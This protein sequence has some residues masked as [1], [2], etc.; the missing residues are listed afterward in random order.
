VTTPIL[1]KELEETGLFDVT[2]A[3]APHSDD[4]FSTFKPDFSLYQVVVCNLDS[5]DWP[6]ELKA[7]FEQYMRNGGG[8]V[9]VHAADNA[10]PN[11]PAYNEMTGIGGWR[12]RTEKAGPLWYIKN[13]KVVSDPTPG[14][15]GVDF[16]AQFGDGPFLRIQVKS[17]RGAGDVFMEKSKF[18]LHEHRL[19][20]F[21]LL[22]DERPPN[23]FL[24][25]SLEWRTPTALLRDRNYGEG[26]KSTPEWGMNISK[27]NLVLLE[28]YSFER[29]AEAI[30]RRSQ[31]G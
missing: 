4:D 8:L 16:I 13:D 15:R 11:W 22:V 28:P 2:V 18:S 9:V 5:P 23:L 30:V 14:D 19:L 21:G 12:D 31:N 24:I 7:N 25:P 29:T 3:T 20:A 26:L 17:V 6:S 10:F 1:K 27:R